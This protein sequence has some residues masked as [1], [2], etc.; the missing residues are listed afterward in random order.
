MTENKPKRNKNSKQKTNFDQQDVRNTTT[1]NR[2][3]FVNSESV[4]V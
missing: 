3:K 1:T 4:P 2:K